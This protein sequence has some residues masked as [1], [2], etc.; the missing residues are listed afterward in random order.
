MAIHFPESRISCL[1]AARKS[2]L[3]T[4]AFGIGIRTTFK[5]VWNIALDGFGNKTPG[6]RREAQYKSPWDV[7]HPGRSFAER[8][9]TSPA[10]AEFFLQRVADHFAGKPLAKLPKVLAEQEAE[11]ELEAEELAD[12]V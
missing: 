11:A 3:F 4:V 2:F 10:S 1:Q 12:E 9:A 6:K 5:P 8:L 7:V